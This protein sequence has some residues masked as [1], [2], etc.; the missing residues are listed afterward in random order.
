MNHGVI[1]ATDFGIFASL[2]QM[3]NDPSSK[4]SSLEIYI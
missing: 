2:E 4:K 3:E 1:G